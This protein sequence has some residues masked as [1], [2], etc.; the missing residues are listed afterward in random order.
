MF[1]KAIKELPVQ[2]Y[3]R[4]DGTLKSLE[5]DYGIRVY[6]H[7]KLPLVGL[8][9][10]MISDAPLFVKD[11]PIIRSCRGTI[12]HKG[13]FKLEG[14]GFYRFFNYMEHKEDSESFNWSD[15]TV[16][17]KADGSLILLYFSHDKWRANTSG[18]FGLTELEGSGKTWSETF[19]SI[20]NI[21]TSLLN[22]ECTYILEMWSPYNKII[23]IYPKS[24]V[25]LLG[26]MHS[27][28]GDIYEYPI[29][30]VVKTAET[31]SV[32][33]PEIYSFNGFREI[34]RFLDEKEKDDTTF[35]GVVLRD[36][37]NV[38]IKIKTKTYLVLHAL[39]DNNS[40]ANPKNIIPFIL[41]G[42]CSEILTYFP[43]LKEQVMEIEEKL[44]KELK[45]LIA[46][47]E[48]CSRIIEQK[49]FALEIIPKTKFSGLLFRLRQENGS[50][51]DL[52][53]IWRESADIIYK[54]LW[55]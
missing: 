2:T 1:Q 54:F 44:N 4:S 38:R 17:E 49:D 5:N 47:W 40:I 48:G 8:K 20:A 28:D 29:G 14:M 50:V 51:D 34:D 33:T 21:D 25:F 37:S 55:K 53:Q 35:E 11:D 23:R 42:E 16:A 24:T 22:E 15:F 31:L 3:L 52:K 32:Q 30:D 43:E 46:V 19:F 36:N 12:L 41:A 27:M 6:E 7:P 9:Y 45:N 13:T 26:I 39:S 18:S 10:N